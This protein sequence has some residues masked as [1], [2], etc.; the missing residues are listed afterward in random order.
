MTQGDV[1]EPHPDG[2]RET[3]GAR[4]GDRARV[5]DNRESGS[6]WTDRDGNPSDGPAGGADETD[7]AGD[8][9]DDYGPEDRGS[10]LIGEH[11]HETPHPS[12]WPYLERGDDKGMDRHPYCEDCGLVKYVGP[13]RPLPGGGLVNLLGRL[14]DR[15]EREGRTLAD[16][17]KR[18]IL[19]RLRDRNVDDN[20]GQDRATQLAAFEEVVSEV[21]G[22]EESFVHGLLHDILEREGKV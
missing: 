1:D 6:P 7:E 14:K 15:L 2:D 5:V 13:D 9:G 19:Q 17:Q 4:N 16:A 3:G 22:V 8:D 21:T 12:R 10:G 11:A 18:V 20:W